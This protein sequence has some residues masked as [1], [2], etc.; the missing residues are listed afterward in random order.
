[1]VS[2]VLLPFAS[3][4]A[5]T[6]CTNTGYLFLS[7][8]CFHLLKSARLVT[9]CVL[10]SLISL[11]R[12]SIP[13]VSAALLFLAVVKFPSNATLAVVSVS[14]VLLRAP[15]YKYVDAKLTPYKAYKS[16]S[17]SFVSIK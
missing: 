12:A 6:F 9:I 17:N 3:R 8:D 11:L 16:H 4:V 7:V 14:I 13:V 2:H 1:M 10:S 5:S 15:I